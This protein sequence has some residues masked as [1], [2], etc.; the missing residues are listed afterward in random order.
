M[1]D[2]L[3]V[4][5]IWHM[6]QPYY[7]HPQTSEFVLPSPN[8]ALSPTVD[9]YARVSFTPGRGLLEAVS[10]LTQRIF[11]DLSYEPGS[12][13]LST[14]P[15]DVLRKG[16]GVCQD[17]AHLQIASLRSVGLAARYVSGYLE[18]LPLPGELK[19][20][21][22]DASHAWLSVFAPGIGWVDV[23]PTHNCFVGNRCAG[24]KSSPV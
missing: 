2:K 20:Q 11:F 15:D 13:S 7:K 1:K 5:I 6:H 24:L 9:A 21:G 23:D 19:L 3:A 14:R 4:A 22:A 18:T 17:F 12:T 10:D 16:K 8:V